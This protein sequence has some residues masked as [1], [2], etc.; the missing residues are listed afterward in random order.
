MN[1]VSISGDPLHKIHW[2]LSAKTDVF[3]VRKDEGRGIPRKKLILDPVVTRGEKPKTQSAVQREDKILDALISVVDMLVRA[4]RDVEVWLFEY[5]EWMNYL[6]K[7]RDQIAQMQHRL[8]AFK[9]IRSKEELNNERLPMSTIAMQDGNGRIFAGGDA[10][11]FT[12]LFDNQLSETIK[13]MQE[14]KMT[15]D[16]VAIKYDGDNVK[17]EVWQEEKSKAA[18]MN[19]WTIS[20]GDEISEVLV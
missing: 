3:M 11:V 10:M 18:K 16:L 6:I 19:L 4:G 20:L 17:S 14:L 7:D 15:V 9:F 12:A 1:F 2:K 13:G 5:G 8:A